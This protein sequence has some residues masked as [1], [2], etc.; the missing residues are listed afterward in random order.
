MFKVGLKTLTKTE[1]QIFRLYL[2]GKT[3]DEIMEICRIQK[4]TLKY[5]NHNILGKLGV[6]SRKQMLRYATLL[7][8]ENDGS[9]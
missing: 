6:S 4:G 2:D 3:A 8:Q 1:K 5:H 9:L 7:K